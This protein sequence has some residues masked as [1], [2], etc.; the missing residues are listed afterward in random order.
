MPSARRATWWH[1]VRWSW[2]GDFYPRPPRGGR[3]TSCNHLVE[4]IKISIHALR[5]EGDPWHRRTC[6]PKHISIHALR[7]EGDASCRCSRLV[8][9]RFLSTPSARRATAF[10]FQAGVFVHISIHALREEG[11]VPSQCLSQMLFSISIHALREEGDYVS[12]AITSVYW[13]FYP[14]PPRGG[15]QGPDPSSGGQ[16]TISIHALR[17]EGD[18]RML[19]NSAL[20]SLFLSTPSARRATL[21]SLYHD[22]TPQISIH[23]LREEGD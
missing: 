15:R 12:Y 1:S 3:L 18:L 14:R 8:N 11:D 22:H 7:E 21:L 4:T 17:E 5:E 23:A 16:M 20:I 2:S 9:E 19:L 13:N 6:W 10:V